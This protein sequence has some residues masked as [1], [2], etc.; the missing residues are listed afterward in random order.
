MSISKD[1]YI[2]KSDDILDKYDNTYHST[3]KIKLVNVKSSIYLDFDKKNNKRHLKFEVADYV[4]LSKCKNIFAKG[5][6]PNWSE[7]V[8]VIAKS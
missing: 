4:R 8:F 5:Y 3:I 2:N 1:L 7:E 6:I